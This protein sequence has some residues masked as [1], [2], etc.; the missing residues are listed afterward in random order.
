MVGTEFGGRQH[1]YEMFY[2]GAPFITQLRN[3]LVYDWSRPR[4]LLES[5]LSGYSLPEVKT[6]AD[7][8]R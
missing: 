6:T 8:D 3:Y 2:A 1:Q 4:Q 7:V 5:F